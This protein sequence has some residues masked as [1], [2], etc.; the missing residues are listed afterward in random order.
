MLYRIVFLLFLIFFGG[1]QKFTYYLG[2]SIFLMK[3]YTIN[4]LFK[5]ESFGSF[6]SF[7]VSISSFVFEDFVQLQYKIAQN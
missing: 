5:K 4:Y 2:L 3:L 6:V 1:G 7:R